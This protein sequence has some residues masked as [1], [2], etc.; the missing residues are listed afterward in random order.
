MSRNTTRRQ[1]EY[2]NIHICYKLLNFCF[3]IHIL[4]VDFIYFPLF[5]LNIKHSNS[6]LKFH[7]KILANSTNQRDI[8]Q[9]PTP[10]YIILNVLCE[11]IYNQSKKDTDLILVLGVNL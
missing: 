4:K 8:S 5:R 3:K 1:H 11:L 6:N 7:I 10:S 9:K 2:E